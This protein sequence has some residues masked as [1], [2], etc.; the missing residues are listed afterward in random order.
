MIHVWN[1]NLIKY[2]VAIKIIHFNYEDMKLEIFVISE[3]GMTK[4]CAYNVSRA[5]KKHV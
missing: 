3:Q 5:F 1:N 2:Y 4:Y